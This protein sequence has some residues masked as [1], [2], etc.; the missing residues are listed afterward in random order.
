MDEIELFYDKEFK[1][2]VSENISFEPIN[3]GEQTV[4]ELYI[5][6]NL[7]YKLN[8]EMNFDNQDIIYNK[9]KISIKPLSTIKVELKFNPK[10]SIT[11]PINS[12]FNIKIDYLIT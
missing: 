3:A 9:E 6:N 11:K 7:K 8:L 5:K 12:K 1:N 2:K 4:K 10:L